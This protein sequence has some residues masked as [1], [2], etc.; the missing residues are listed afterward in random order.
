MKKKVN[1]GFQ[2]LVGLVVGDQL[3]KRGGLS[4]LEQ[5][6]LGWT[7]RPRAHVAEVAGVRALA[8]A[9]AVHAHPHRHAFGTGVQQAGDV[10]WVGQG[11]GRLVTLL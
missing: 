10:C 3:V 9:A 1:Q 5:D 4:H 7:P 11:P 6:R 8:L 2:C